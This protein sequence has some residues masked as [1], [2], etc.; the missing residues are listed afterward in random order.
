MRSLEVDSSIEQQQELVERLWEMGIPS[1]QSSV[2]RDLK[3]LGIVRAGGCYTV[4]GRS[5]EESLFK[6]LLPYVMEARPAG[7]HMTFIKTFPGAGPLVAK[8]IT[9]ENGS[10]TFQNRT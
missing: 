10:R 9:A 5:E 2:S 8:G 1:T 4:P 3:A 7:H 6:G